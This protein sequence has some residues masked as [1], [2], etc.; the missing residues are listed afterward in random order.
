[1][2]IVNAIRAA[3]PAPPVAVDTAGRDKLAGVMLAEARGEG[4]E[5]MAG[6]GNVVLNRQAAGGNRFPKTID[7]VINNEFAKPL[8][9]NDVLPEEWA[10]ATNL[11]TQLQNGAVPDNTGGAVYFANTATARSSKYAQ[12]AASGPVSTTI[13]N[14]TY[15]VDSKIGP[16][17]RTGAPQ[18]APVG[19]INLAGLT[20]PSGGTLTPGVPAGTEAYA[21][22]L[23]GAGGQNGQDGQAAIADLLGLPP[24]PVA[25]SFAPT[26]PETASPA[27][28]RRPG[29]GGAIGVDLGMQPAGMP[30]PPSRPGTFD[31]LGGG[32]PEAAMVPPPGISPLRPAFGGPGDRRP[33]PPIPQLRPDALGIPDPRMRPS[34]PQSPVEAFSPPAGPSDLVPFLPPPAATAAPAIAPPLERT[35]RKYSGQGGPVIP[36]SPDEMRS[37]LANANANRERTLGVGWRGNLGTPETAMSIGR[38]GVGPVGGFDRAARAGQIMGLPPSLNTG[39]FPISGGGGSDALAAGN[40]S[41]LSPP[42][43]A[44]MPPALMPSGDPWASAYGQRPDM[45]A[46]L[47]IHNIATAAPEPRY[48]PLSSIH[49]PPPVVSSDIDKIPGVTVAA[50]PDNITLPTEP[51]A[52]VDA[53]QAPTID[54]VVAAANQPHLPPPPRQKVVTTAAA[55]PT[56]AAEEEKKRNSFLSQFLPGGGSIFG[57]G[58]GGFFS[59]AGSFTPFA[60]AGG[61]SPFNQQPNGQMGRTTWRQGSV[62]GNPAMS[63]VMWNRSG[64]NGSVGYVTDPITGSMIYSGS[65]NRF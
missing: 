22:F 4:R 30:P 5:G 47:G 26:V 28:P 19:P 54:P 46:Q 33:Q 2:T 36:I 27:A 31:W 25:Q 62:T 60:G 42:P 13:G 9:P 55:T 64:N 14:H 43:P 44:L 38:G 59:N 52:Q 10:D 48:D 35:A 57:I 18:S 8:G 11:A 45:A 24:P 16:V 32:A 1:M 12:I 3:N 51:T 29:P 17:A 61:T 65:P 7:E 56:K 41:P 40:A 15:H 6:V 39:E 49:L 21:P 37:S 20:N 63:G 50:D 34:A 53:E 58:P 23:P